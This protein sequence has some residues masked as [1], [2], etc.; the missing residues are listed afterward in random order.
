MINSTPVKYIISILIALVLVLAGTV[1][2]FGQVIASAELQNIQGSVYLRVPGCGW[3]A[4][5]SRRL[6]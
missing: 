1:P 6:D 4:G 2:V 5:I 3:D